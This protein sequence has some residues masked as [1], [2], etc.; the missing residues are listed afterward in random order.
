MKN[1][2][3][4]AETN[5]ATYCPEDDKLRLYVGRVPRDEYLALKAEGWTSTPKQDCDFVATWTTSREDTAL[6]YAG[7]ILDEDQGPEDR[8]AD[9][10][11]RFGGYLD[12]RREEAHGFA[13]RY[14]SVPTVHGYQ[15]YTKAVR[16]ADRHDRIAD[17]AVN[18]WD[19]AEYWQRR[20]A[21]VISHALYRSNPGVRFRRIKDIEAGIRKDEKES[22][23]YDKLRKLWV[24]VAA[25][26][27]SEKQK[28][29]ALCVS[30]YGGYYNG[31]YHHPRQES[32]SS[33][34][35]EHGTSLYSLLS[36]EKDPITGAEAAELY[37]TK[38]SDQEGYESRW[39]QH[40]RLRLAYEQQML[41]AEG[42][43]AG[44]LE[45]E[46]GGW[47]GKYQ[48]LKVNKS[49]ATGRV[50]SVTVKAPLNRY[51]SFDKDGKEYGPDNPRPMVNTVLK[52][53][54]C[55]K[56]VYRAPTEEDKESLETKKAAE[57]KKPKDP[58]LINPT[59]EDAEK[60]QEIWNDEFA[61]RCKSW[62]T[63][64]VRSTVIEMTQ[65]EYA[66]ASKAVYGRNGNTV[67]VGEDGNETYIQYRGN[68]KEGAVCKVRR[69]FESNQAYR[70]IILTDKPQKHLPSFALKAEEVK[71]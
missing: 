60:L 69:W 1:E 24:N 49:N 37:L 28:R 18:A 63:P 4:Y 53:E 35:R 32:A 12:K 50:V 20:T 41:E 39:L 70:V 16:A 13:D 6:S 34:A 25:I 40:Q 11:E 14:D 3:L 17:K 44:E 8:A 38:H 52:V 29:A 48:I 27:D 2:N 55:A 54:D 5:Q 61:K 43:R 23:K 51:I 45:M 47:I 59:R 7:I 36:Q 42:G 68:V 56:S 67:F 19:K 46:V 26:T 65:D 30:N 71:A 15:D 33:Y 10:A 31:Y 22:E 9:R 66:A 21:G 64:P 58:P 62:Y 57:P